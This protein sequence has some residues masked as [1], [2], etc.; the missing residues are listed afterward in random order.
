MAGYRRTAAQKTH[1]FTFS[2][3]WE[4]EVKS[5][6]P[7]YVDDR[8]KSTTELD[9]YVPGAYIDA[10]EKNQP[11]SARWDLPTGC[12]EKDAFIIDELSIRKALKHFPLSYFVLHDRPQGRVF[13]ARADVMALAS[14]TR[15]MRVNKGKRVVD[16]RNFRLLTDPAAQLWPAILED[17]LAMNWKNSE[18]LTELQIRQV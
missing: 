18:C 8:T 6:L 11:I 9:F 14:A 3:L 1:D 4:Q 17:Q 16:L 15:L 7:P 13:L 5:W 2:K 10:K 12:D